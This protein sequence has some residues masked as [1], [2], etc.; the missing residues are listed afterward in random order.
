M[1][2]ARRPLA[3][4]VTVALA[5]STLVAEHLFI[6]GQ[7]RRGRLATV[8]IDGREAVDGEVIVRYRPEAGSSG[9]QRAEFDVDSDEVETVGRRGA[10]RMRSR[11][12]GTR[13]MLDTLRGNPDVDYAEPNYI[14]RLAAV[15]NDAS[16]GN[17]WGLFNSGQTIA[18]VAG[19]PG[20]DIDAPGAWN[21]TTGSRASVVGVI[22][23]GIDYN[24]PDLAA[25]MW[26]APRPF[27][28]V[29]GGLVINCAAGTHGFN[30]INNSCNPM[31]DHAHGTHVAGTIG[32]AG[33][34][35]FG[36]TGVNWVA[37]MMGLK[38][39]SS[40]GSGTTTDAIKAIEFA[41]QAKA[42]LGVDANVRILSNSWGGGGYSIALANQIE[43]S[44]NA[45]MLFVAAAGNSGV[46]T[47]ISPHYPSSY[48]NASVVSVLSSTN[49]DQ[50]SGFSNYGAASVDL[51]APGSAIVSTTPN[52]TYSSYN[53]TSMATPHV[54]G[55]AALI[56]SVCPMNT[57]AL[58]SL[59][60]SSVDLPASLSGLTATGGRLDVNNAV[61][62]CTV[63]RPTVTATIHD[64]TV[65]ATVNNGPGNFDDRLE[66]YCP[67]T[68]ADGGYTSFKYLNNQVSPPG[69]GYSAA[70]VT[71]A[72]PSNVGQ[73]CH[74]R[75]FG[76]INGNRA[77]LATSNNVVIPAKP[78]QLTVGTPSVSPGGQISVGITDGTRNSTDWVGLY[79]AGAP[80]SAFLEWNFLNGMKSA[81]AIGIE[82]TTVFF[83]AP[84]TSGNYEVRLFANNT[85]QRLATSSAITV[86]SQPSLTIGDV[87]ITEGNSGSAN[88]AFVV[89]LSPV[90]ATQAVTVNFTTANGTATSGIDYVAASGTLT[91]APGTASQSI[92]VAVLGDAVAET[93]ETFFVNLSNATNAALGDPQAIGTIVT[94]EAPPAPAIALQSA[95]VAPGGT[96]NFNVTNGPANRTDWVGFFPSAAGDASYQQ[97]FYLNGQK[98]APVTGLSN[99]AMQITAPQAAGTYNIRLFANNGST[100]L[101]TSAIITVAAQPTLTINDVTVAEGSAGTVN[102]V[103]TVTLS[104]ANASQAVTVSYNTA[105][106]TASSSSD[107][108]VAAGSVTFA[109]NVDRAQIEVMIRGDAVQEASETF[110]L[111]L[112]NA[113]NAAIGD[114]QGVATITDDDGPAGPSVTLQTPNVQP[115]GTIDFT[116]LNGPGNVA[117]WVSLTAVGTADTAPLRWVYLNGLTSPP[118]AGRTT[119]ALSFPAPLAAGQYNIRFFVNNTYVKIA[120]SATITVAT[121]PT[122]TINDVTIAEGNSGTSNATFTVTL[123]PMNPTQSVT[124]D[125]ATAN[126]TATSA[127]NDYAAASG[128]LTFA[129]NAASQTITVPVTGD[130]DVEGNE[131]FFVNL[132]NAGNAVIGDAQGLGTI[133]TDDLPAGPSI[134]LTTPTVAVG[135]T[136]S[137]TVNNGPGNPTDWV[138]LALSTAPDSSYVRWLY[139]N[140]MN[141]PPASGMASAS[142][143]MAAP[144][145]P[146]TYTI[147]LYS[148]NTYTR[149]A[150]SATITVTP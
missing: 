133:N 36:V 141:V 144:A 126:G 52:N 35:G 74:V 5:L 43:A 70:T 39:L 44:S 125:Y 102:A 19:V 145:V 59:L 64:R 33:N 82:T 119:A 4:A 26:T 71:L 137:F 51:A 93:N 123:S 53:G 95:S 124:V 139:L 91:F 127:N 17:L 32:A 146:G 110:T 28:V 30:A 13:A 85:Y 34:N 21:F 76:N 14:I 100:K 41:I 75:M 142:L 8:L 54:S 77:R 31:D 42:A 99:A 45:D 147:R 136:I 131:T 63:G 117:D 96:I 1:I 58:K 86:A 55:A 25:N 101:A 113:V 73:S 106:G 88:A 104:P 27:A 132:S 10:R 118:A 111:N 81:P 84:M 134:T 108:D 148:N 57:P 38:F 37:S 69:A 92:S 24:H 83:T 109:P 49:R 114:S 6:Q 56:L 143:Q 60:L 72:A 116:V 16:F 98:T 94:D 135:A 23:T 128:T 97:W 80:D 107:Y 120:T 48:T 22:D 87:S 130:T 29:V 20:A 122:L 68:S 67:A 115:G 50:R 129:P 90:N 150:T 46:N 47:D 89:T 65:T 9:R 103:F 138:A 40:S 7:G 12:L 121:Q 66:L 3:V 61:Q 140:G 149:L 105:D 78:P 18:G 79:A 2:S 11:R 112:A 62:S 15:P